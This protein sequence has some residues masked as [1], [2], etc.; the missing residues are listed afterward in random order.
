VGIIEEK[1]AQA[2]TRLVY[3]PIGKAQ[4]LLYMEDE[5]TEIVIKATDN[6]DLNAL[7]TK[8]NNELGIKKLE[9]NT[10]EDVSVFFVEIMKK[11]NAV[12]FVLC[13]IFYIV[14]ISSITNTMILTL[15]ERKKEIGTMMAIGI[16]AK[17]VI[18]LIVM[19]STIIGF[20]GS[21]I[22]ILISV[23]FILI[24]KNIGLTYTPP[25]GSSPLTIYPLFSQSF[26]LLSFILGVLSAIIAAIYPAKKVLQ[27]NPVDAI[28]T[29]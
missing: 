9:S 13:L 1:A 10:W 5:V 4:E 28:R 6:S 3:I 8:L 20:V 14:V 17:H 11:Q 19:E 24:L 7:N 18:R 15:F 27:M 22:G 26:M 12:T 16:K 29:T 21:L 23:L 2:N 25:G